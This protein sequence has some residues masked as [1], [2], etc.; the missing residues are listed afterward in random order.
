MV[1]IAGETHPLFKLLPLLDGHRV[2]LCK[3]RNNVDRVT[4]A[5]HELD[6]ER[7]EADGQRRTVS[8]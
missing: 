7:S 8:Q 4:Q 5:L 6:V 1:E 2:G 3:D